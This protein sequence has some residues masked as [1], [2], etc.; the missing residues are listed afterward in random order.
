MAIRIVEKLAYTFDDV[1][2][3]P[4]KSLPSRSMANTSTE[5]AGIKLASPI[6]SANMDTVTEVNMAIAMAKCGGL[7]ILHRYALPNI[8]VDWIK[9]LCEENFSPIPSIGVSGLDFDNSLWY[10]EA[11]AEAICLDVANAYSNKALSRIRALVDSGFR[12]I[13]GNVA[14]VDAAFA[15]ADAGACAVKV[16]IGPGSVCTTRIVT[17]HGFPQLSAIDNIAV[18]MESLFPHVKIIADGGIRNSGDIVKAIAAGADA[19]MI[20]KLF[21]G[22]DEAPLGNAY[23]GMAS[24]EARHG[25]L[26]AQVAEGVATEVPTTGPVEGVVRD[27]VAGLR[28]GM[29]YS[30]ASTLYELRQHAEFVVVTQNAV[31]E[32]G[33]H[34]LS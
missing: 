26:N 16:G 1:L 27:L 29:S 17:G 20:G 28:S 6:I 15:L 12:V 10:M 33:P 14:T 32:N 21:A 9:R 7:G 11:G 8:V 25:R 23:R 4:G 34:G 31:K 22:C 30:G 13:A 5:I 3:V 24:H 18:K 19:V 2:L